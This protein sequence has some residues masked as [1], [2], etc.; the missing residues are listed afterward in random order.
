MLSLVLAPSFATVANAQRAS[1]REDLYLPSYGPSNAL[2]VVAVVGGLLG[3]LVATAPAW[4]S[5]CPPSSASFARICEAGVTM[6]IVGLGL[7]VL[8]I[9]LGIAASVMHFDVRAQR[10]AHQRE[11]GAWRF[12]PWVRGDGG[13]LSGCVWW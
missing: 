12:T 4:A 6:N 8:S 10:E 5:P 2:H 9:A 11:R 7:E 3:L 13:G 1:A